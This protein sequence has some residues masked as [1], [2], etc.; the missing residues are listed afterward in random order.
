M[1]EVYEPYCSSE[2]SREGSDSSEARAHLLTVYIEEAHASDE[3]FLPDARAVSGPDTGTESSTGGGPS[4]AV[5]RSLEDRLA[6]AR[7]LV[8]DTGL[9]G[10]VAVDG[11]G[12]QVADR[13]FAWPERLYI[14][15]D[16]RV[17]YK[18]DMGPNGYRI[19]EVVQWLRDRYGE[20]GD[21]HEEHQ[22][23]Q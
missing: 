14:I 17:V 12:N 19:E 16:G 1:R 11:M 20:W 9:K 4:I 6:A 21:L 2:A 13:Y 22:E 18:S 8:A 5:H 3:W 10:Q 23:E 15:L 7:R